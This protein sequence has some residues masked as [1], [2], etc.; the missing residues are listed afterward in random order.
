MVVV[1]GDGYG[2]WLHTGFFA[3]LVAREEHHQF[4]EKQVEIISVVQSRAVHLFLS[5]NL[6]GGRNYHCSLTQ[7]NY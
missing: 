2:G 5:N 6:H 3:S 7:Q 4:K 1:G